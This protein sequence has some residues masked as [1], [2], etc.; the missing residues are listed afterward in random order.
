M[1][2]EY[3]ANQAQSK[4]EHLI[5]L[6]KVNGKL[7]ELTQEVPR[8][9]EVQFITMGERVGLEVYRRSMCFLL[10]K[11][12]KDLYGGERVAHCKIETSVDKGLYCHFVDEREL[13]E[14]FI[15][16]VWKQMNVLAERDIPIEKKTMLTDDAIRLFA[17]VQMN[18]KVQLFHYRRA[19]T[20]NIYYLGEYA[21]Y[22]YGY[23]VPSTRYLK[24]FA[25]YSYGEG[26]VMQMP[27]S[28]QP[29]WVKPF[30]P[31]E[32]LFQVL[33]ERQRWQKH[34]GIYS[35][36]DLNDAISKGK[37][38]E[39]ILVQE[40]LMEK[41]I[42]DIAEQICASKRNK[43]ILIAGPSSSGKTTFSHRLAIQ[44]MAHGMRPHPVEVDNYFVNRKD[45][46]RDENGN[47]DFEALS[48]IDRP[49]LHKDVQDMLAG[50]CVKLPTYNFLTGCREY[51]GESLQLG[52]EDVIILEGIHC[53]NPDLLEHVADGRVFKI[54]ISALTQMNVDMHNRISTTDGRL[55]RRLVR[56]ARKRGNSAQDTLRMWESVRRGEEKNIFPYQEEAD[57]I[58]NSSLLYEFAVLKPYVEPLLFG[59]ARGEEEYAEANRLLKF[60]D[61]FLGI[62]S[63]EIPKNSIIREFIGGSC[64]KV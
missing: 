39:V 22:F 30:E 60:F 31:T 35:V 52:R 18:D 29:N 58:F 48:C 11:A 8:D 50:K 55:I 20:A 62:N 16:R 7:Q 57:A 27:S 56:D 43:I 25:L 59:I 1:R 42:A 4:Y 3:L 24:H 13:E 61:Y 63:E 5:V 21:D 36:G 53:L 17:E 45:S 38:N 46:P 2:L 51:R 19:S 14:D 47:Y 15:E 40:A 10:L 9:A 49:L 26:F 23:M 37:M 32:K 12:V 54:Y 34:M 28:K 64:F 33:Q 41:R 44:L 6:A